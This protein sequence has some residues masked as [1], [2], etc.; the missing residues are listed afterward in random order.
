VIFDAYVKD[1]A[2]HEMEGCVIGVDFVAGGFEGVRFLFEKRCGLT[3]LK[4]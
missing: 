3:S 2:K 1:A 4:E